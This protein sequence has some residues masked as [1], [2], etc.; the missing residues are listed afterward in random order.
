[1][2]HVNSGMR[3]CD[4]P[5]HAKPEGTFLLACY[6]LHYAVIPS[7]YPPLRDLSMSREKCTVVK[8]IAKGV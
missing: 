4:P 8:Q 3:S 7:S 2:I 1:M 5:K 6:G